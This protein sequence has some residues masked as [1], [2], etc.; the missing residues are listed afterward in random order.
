MS[1]LGADVR[2]HEV[3][4]PQGSA[5]SERTH[6]VAVALTALA[7]EVAADGRQLVWPPVG[8]EGSNDGHIRGYVIP[9]IPSPDSGNLGLA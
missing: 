9:S 6:S 4:G 2:F 7:T 5:E 3:P 8:V 1:E